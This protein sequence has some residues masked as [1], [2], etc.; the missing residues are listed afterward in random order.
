[1]FF[2]FDANRKG[3]QRTFQQ[4]TAVGDARMTSMVLS[5]PEGREL[6]QGEDA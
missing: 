2:I 4:E 5:A 3:L 1:V 6:R